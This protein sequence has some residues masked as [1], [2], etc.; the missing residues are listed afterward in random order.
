MNF[1]L[2]SSFKN[3]EAL[4][5]LAGDRRFLSVLREDREVYAYLLGNADGTPTHLIAWHPVAAEDTQTTTIALPMRQAPQRAWYL[6]GQSSEGTTAPIPRYQ[7]GSWQLAV[8]SVPVLV[9]VE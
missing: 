9:E 6:D 5:R 2:K 4:R 7:N 3:I 8:S 1:A